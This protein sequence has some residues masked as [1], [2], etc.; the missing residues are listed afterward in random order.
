MSNSGGVYTWSS[1][2]AN[3]ATADNTVNWSEGQAPSSIN[4]SARAL[5]A[6]VS[7]W[8]DDI[9]GAIVTTGISTAYVLSSNQDFDTAADLSGNLIAFSPHVTNGAGPV[10]LIVDGI[11]PFPLR[12]APNTD[13]LAGTIIQGTPYIA[14][15]NNTNGEFYLQGFYGQPL[16]IPLFGGM[17]FWDTIAPN[18]NFIFPLGQAISRTAFPTAF[19]RWGT[20]FGVG[21]G[22]TTFNVPNKAGRVSAMTEP[23]ASL[24][25]SAFFGA[26]STVIGSK[27]GAQDIALTTPNLPA[28]TPSGSVGVSVTA[29]FGG[30]FTGAFEGGAGAEGLTTGGATAVSITSQSGSFTGNA[31]GGTSTAFRTVQPTITCNYI[32]RI[33]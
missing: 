7:K 12:T 9:A 23:T 8:S 32:I 27:G 5:M 20:M 19:A 26:N 17:D 24:L 13:L 28:Y 18:S 22:S 3:N 30:T 4:D 11:G 1:T 2:A 21:D 10:T 16:A 25:T 31:Q 33:V 29:S 6:S 15:F 14:L